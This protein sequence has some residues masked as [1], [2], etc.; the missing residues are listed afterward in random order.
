VVAIQYPPPAF[1]IRS[2][3]GREFIFDPQ[4]KKWLLLT[5]EEWVRQNFIQ[6]LLQVK[7]Y[8]STLVAI[9][10]EI[11]L[12]ELKKRFDILVYDRQHRPWMMIECK[13]M[14][15]ALNDE[16]L[17]QLLRYNIS[18]PVP[19]LVI[20]NGAY[21]FAAERKSGGLEVLEEIPD[22]SDL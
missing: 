14:E 1:R 3:N 6:Y 2:E 10:K 8:P 11:R 15:I 19:Y 7:K 4:R 5:P 17:D 9:E 22:L 21:C 16:V 20:T 13:G 12:G 18:V